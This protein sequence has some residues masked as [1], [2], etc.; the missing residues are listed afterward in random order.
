MRAEEAPDGRPIR[1]LVRRLIR[2][3]AMLSIIFPLMLLI[4]GYVAWHRWGAQYMTDQFHRLEPQ[5]IQVTVPPQYVR[6]DV[7]ESVYKDTAMEG[8]SLLDTQ[9]TAKIASAFSTHPW[10]RRVNSVRKLPG[11]KIDIRLD[12]RKPVAMVRVDSRRPSVDS[13]SS[14]NWDRFAIDGEGILLPSSDF[15]TKEANDYIHI[16]VPEVYPTGANFGNK[17][18]EQRVEAAA[19]VAALVAPFREQAPIAEIHVNGDL[20][21]NAVP[22]MEL[23]TDDG[24]TFTWGSAPGMEIPGESL[25][26]TK[27][28]LLVMGVRNKTDL[29]IASLP[30]QE[31]H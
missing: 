17:F 21:I 29:R 19:R 18:G 5:Q 28:K 24:R 2:A 3:P 6:S 22:Q 15:T 30:N 9:A 13:S 14:S 1:S 8:L 4:G 16:I 25:A 12:Y 26:E 20:R 10:V 31:T 11:G 23:V 7:V 27:I